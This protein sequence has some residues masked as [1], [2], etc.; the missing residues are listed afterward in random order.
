ML[1]KTENKF[2]KLILYAILNKKGETVIWL[3][4][5]I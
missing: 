1:Y 5:K 2:T 3:L 4:E